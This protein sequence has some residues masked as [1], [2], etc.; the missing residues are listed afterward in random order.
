MANMEVLPWM[1][2]SERVK[3][4]EQI[5]KDILDLK[6]RYEDVLQPIRD[7]TE[8]V[9]SLTGDVTKLTSET[10]GIAGDVGD[11]NRLWR[12]QPTSNRTDD[13]SRKNHWPSGRN[14][15]ADPGVGSVWPKAGGENNE[16]TDEFRSLSG[17]DL[18]ALG[19]TPSRRG[20]APACAVQESF[21]LNAACDATC[22]A[23]TRE[24]LRS[25]VSCYRCA[26]ASSKG[27][28]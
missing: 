17:I 1:Q 2:I 14:S 3:Q 20:C 10:R 16:F 12:E 9:Q 19:V 6:A 13:Q 26:M 25:S 8:N 4:I 11:L 23:R 7:L 27:I 15:R 28:K 24:T 18:L 22:T 21:R 5:T